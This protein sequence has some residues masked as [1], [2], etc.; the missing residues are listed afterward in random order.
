M[1][2]EGYES[3]TKADVLMPSPEVPQLVEFFSSKNNMYY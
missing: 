1:E 3:Y 2:F